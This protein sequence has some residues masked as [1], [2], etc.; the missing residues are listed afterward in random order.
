MVPVGSPAKDGVAS[1]MIHKPLIIVC[2]GRWYRGIAIEL[3]SW[4]EGGVLL[5]SISK[6][7]ADHA[8]YPIMYIAQQLGRVIGVAG[9]AQHAGQAASDVVRIIECGSS[10]TGGSNQIPGRIVSIVQLERCGNTR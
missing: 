7:S 2:I 10:D 5:H 9:R 3:A 6:S 1:P 4:R 8:E